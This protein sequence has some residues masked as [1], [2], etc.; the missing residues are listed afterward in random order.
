[1]RVIQVSPTEV[2]I[3]LDPGEDGDVRSVTVA[4]D[5]F[6]GLSITATEKHGSDTI[7]HAHNSAGHG[8]DAY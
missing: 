1:M 7:T 2:R 8:C 4:R 3:E 6:D 5:D